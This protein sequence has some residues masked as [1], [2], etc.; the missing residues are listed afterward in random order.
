MPPAPTEP[1]TELRLGQYLLI[2]LARPGHAP[3]TI[4]VVLLDVAADQ[5]YLRFRRDWDWLAPDEVDVLSALEED[6]DQAAR[7]MGASA[8]VGW[9]EDSLSN[10]L[11]TGDREQVTMASADKTLSA[12]YRKHVSSQILEFKTHLPLYSARAA[13]TKFS[14]Q[15][16]VSSEGWLEVFNVPRLEEGM[17]IC[18]VEGRSM[19]PKIPS[20]SLCV[21]RAGVT[22]SRQGRLVLVENRA[23]RGGETERYTIKQYWSEK[24]QHPEGWTH[25]RILLKPLNPDYEAWELDESGTYAVIAEFVSVLDS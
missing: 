21:F 11:R 14:E 22:G 5:V 6:M 15:Q 3:E 8:F 24:S 2:D 9:L 12:L 25:T 23:S 13:A 1:A 17:F 7:Q 4:G 19:E 16:D 20:G 18:R 10:E